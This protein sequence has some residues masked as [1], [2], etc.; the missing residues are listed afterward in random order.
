M[1]FE[2]GHRKIGGRKKGTPN[3]YAEDLRN[4]LKNIVYDELENI[5]DILDQLPPEKRIDVFLKL[6]PFVLPKVNSVVMD[7]G[8]P[9]YIRPP[10]KQYRY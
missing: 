1:P 3:R 8:E 9:K 6:A 2:K 4:I 10:E 5:P 7:D